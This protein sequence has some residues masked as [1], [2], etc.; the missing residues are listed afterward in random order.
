MSFRAPANVTIESSFNHIYSAKKWGDQGG[1]SGSGSSEFAGAGAS[2]ILYYVIMAFNVHSMI[3]APCGAMVWQRSLLQQLVEEPFVY[4]GIDVVHKIVQQNVQTFAGKWG[5]FR[6]NSRQHAGFRVSFSHANL[7]APHWSAPRGYDMIFS[8]D[9]LQHNKRADVWSI[10]RAF[11][12]SDAKLLL[13]GSYPDG[14]T[15][16]HEHRGINHEIRTGDFFCVD[17]AL[18]PY[19]LKPSQI[20]REGTLDRKALYLYERARVREALD[21]RRPAPK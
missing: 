4:H 19:N 21:A 17:L 2:R 11:A 16:C 8:R 5:H 7:A 18:E 14:S 6:N 3:D 13:L 9:A 20:F 12:K 10:L 15:H 1:G